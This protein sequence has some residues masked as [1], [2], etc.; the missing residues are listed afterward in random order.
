MKYLLLAATATALFFSAYW[1]LMRNEKRHTMVRFYLVGTLLLALLLPSVHLRLSVPQHYIARSEAADSI[2]SYPGESGLPS[3]SRLSSE[4]G[5]VG[6]RP[7]LL[8][9]QWL[10]L[11]G[12]VAS[13][14]LLTV[15]LVGLW[16]RM[17][18]LP[19]VEHD[20][21]QVALLDDDTSAYSF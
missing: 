19:F 6:A 9:W 5:A 14:A 16:R 15:R 12:V 7:T 21:L 17:R 1:L 10:W 2:Y 8:L 11:A 13:A 3:E 4:P 18:R 20:G